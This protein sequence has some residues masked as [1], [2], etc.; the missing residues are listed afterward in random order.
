MSDVVVMVLCLASFVVGVSAPFGYLPGTDLYY[1]RKYKADQYVKK[2]KYLA[3]EIN[4]GRIVTDVGFENFRELFQNIE[5]VIDTDTESV[6]WRVKDLGRKVTVAKV[7]FDY[8]ERV[9]D[10][11]D[12][13]IRHYSIK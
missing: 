13:I 4:K 6:A 2:V 10:D 11:R 1:I 9:K 7:L 5:K 8:T 12:L 3:N